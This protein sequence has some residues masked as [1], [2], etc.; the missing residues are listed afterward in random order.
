MSGPWLR[1]EAKIRNNSVS[2]PENVRIHLMVFVSQC[3]LF[4]FSYRVHTEIRTQ[5]SRTFPGLFKEFSHFF[6]DLFSKDSNSPNT[7][8]MQDF[9]LIG[10]CKHISPSSSLFLPISALHI[11]FACYFRF[12]LSRFPPCKVSL[13]VVFHSHYMYLNWIEYHGSTTAEHGTTLCFPLPILQFSWFLLCTAQKKTCFYHF[14]GL[15]VII[16][17]IFSKFQHHVRTNALF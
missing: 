12:C 11:V 9:F 15:F 14:Q 10:D 17:K 4:V 6:Q 5:N 16:K 7:A 1:R 8:Y 2:S 3:F 13:P